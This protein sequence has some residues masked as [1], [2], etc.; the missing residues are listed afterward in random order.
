MDWWRD[1]FWIMLATAITTVSAGL[2]F[3]LYCVCRWQLK[4][5]PQETSCQRPVTYSS[6]HKDRNKKLVSIPSYTEPE[7][8]Y[9]DVEIPTTI[10]NNPFETMI[11]SFGQVE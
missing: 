6:V 4:Q 11:C 8:D 2:G 3:L 10:G 5:A 9:D 7:E 1:N